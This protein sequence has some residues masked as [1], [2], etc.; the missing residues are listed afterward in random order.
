M[1]V[2]VFAAA[3][4]VCVAAYALVGSNDKEDESGTIEIE[5]ALGRKVMIDY[6][7][8]RLVV[9]CTG[10]NTFAAVGGDGFFDKVVGIT[11]ELEQFDKP[12]WDAYCQR[13]PGLADAEVVGISYQGTFSVEKIISLNPDV[14]ILSPYLK[15]LGML[16]QS[17]FD[18]MD[19]A[20]VKYIFA[21]FYNDA[22]DEG[23]YDK[24]LKTIGKIL[25]QEERAQQVIDFFNEEVEKVYSRLPESDNKPTVY[26]E[27][28]GTPNEVPGSTAT[29]GNPMLI[30]G[31]SHNIA[32]D[33]S[34]I[35]SAGWGYMSLEFLMTKNP[36]WIVLFAGGFY[37]INLTKY[38]GIGSDP[39]EE[40]LAAMAH[41]YMDRAGWDS[42]SAVKNG[43]V[44]FLQSTLNNSAE[45]FVT[46]Q[47]A[48]KWGYPELFEDLNPLENLE[49]F[50]EEF[51]PLGIS[52]NWDYTPEA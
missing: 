40:E 47:Y 23:M 4:L 21:G 48:A 52:G 45:C 15:T 6:P 34:I 12:L 19:S 8:D 38:F 50:Y 26:Y 14:V 20:G 43:R 17:V 18:N 36:D 16:D 35:K 11:G 3:L 28:L 1:A 42:L 7:V 25:N 2:I 41:S 13:Y 22:L 51:S 46:L 10:F 30:Y 31:G 39:T 29:Y 24:T 44:H 5:D 49:R 37:D 32:E 27:I 33:D 9:E